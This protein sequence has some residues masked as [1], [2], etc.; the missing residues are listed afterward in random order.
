MPVPGARCG[1]LPTGWGT[2]TPRTLIAWI[3]TP[4]SGKHIWLG[5]REP[6]P[7]QPQSTPEATRRLSSEPVAL[8]PAFLHR[9]PFGLSPLPGK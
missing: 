6:V 1:N 9:S 8:S 5:C 4:V 3:L 2:R 7:D